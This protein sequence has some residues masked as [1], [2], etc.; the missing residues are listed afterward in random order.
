MAGDVRTEQ[1]EFA[2][3]EG[4]A[5]IRATLWWPGTEGPR[6]VV[7]LVHGMAEHISRYGPLASFLA[8]RGF[9]V[10]GHDQLGHGSSSAPERWGCLP[11]DVGRDVLVGDVGT[12][13]GLVDD[14][15]SEGTPHFLLGHSMGSF[16]VRSYIARQGAGLAGAIVCGT[17]F[18]PPATSAAGATL[19]RLVCRLHGEDSRSE[20]LH[21]M[22]DGAYA[23]AVPD[24]ETPFDW[25]SH[26][27]DNV[28][29][30]IEDPA[31]GFMFSAGGYATLCDLT[32]ETCTAACARR[33]PKELPLYFIAGEE[34]PV[35]DC[36]R[37]VAR[38][39]ELALSAGAE[40]AGIRLWPGMRHEI[41][42]E[43]GHEAVFEDVCRW[44]EERL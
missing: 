12:L 1:L 4:T 8:S 29:R 18:V 24:A 30:Y 9:L 5:T 39:C 33:V 3:T 21:S 27:H 35:G 22:A 37:G 6:A 32:F 15:V 23:K 41:F 16:V 42:N 43:S 20:L 11:A 2:S 25:L 17:G 19:A 13:R 26:D 38:A 44:M 40:D 28:R 31:C 36:G 10:C 34:D 14:L 7:Q